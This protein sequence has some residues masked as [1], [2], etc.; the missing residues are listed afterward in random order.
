M[1][2][3]T[4]YYREIGCLLPAPHNSGSACNTITFISHGGSFARI[5]A[6]IMNVSGGLLLFE[7][8]FLCPHI[9]CVRVANLTCVLLYSYSA[10]TS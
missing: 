4:R 6:D 2:N 8:P 1:E 5:I 9:E 3:H 7:T 10:V